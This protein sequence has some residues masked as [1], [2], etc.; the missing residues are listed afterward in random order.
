MTPRAPLAAF[1]TTQLKRYALPALLGAA[2]LVSC[3]RDST[4]PLTAPKLPAAQVIP[5][6]TTL[7]GETL[8]AMEFALTGA[9][10]GGTGSFTFTATGTAAGPFVGTFEETATINVSGGTGTFHADFTITSVNSP[11]PIRGS[12][13]GAVATSCIDGQVTVMGDVSYSANING[14]ADEGMA[15]VGLFTDPSSKL[16]ILNEGFQSFIDQK[17]AI[18]TP[19][20]AVNP[21]GTEHTVTATVYVNGQPKQGEIVVFDVTSPL[22]FTAHGTCETDVNGQC[23]FTYTGPQEADVHTITGCP[24]DQTLVAVS[25]TNVCGLATKIWRQEASTPG[26]VTGGGQILHN[27]KIQG[28][29]FGFNAQLS[30]LGRFH[31]SGVVVDHT[32]KTQIK[33]LDVDRLLIVGTHATFEGNAEVNGVGT[34][35]T[36]DVDDLA[37]PGTRGDTFKIVTVSGYMAAGP[38]TQGN[39]QIHK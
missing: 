29:S 30:E 37:E 38:L 34:R 27:L 22:G 5:G 10:P 25:A 13:D 23:P 17:V 11:T 2:T 8:T 26:K 33:I 6:P 7:T 21:V 24:A 4:G 39:I 9:C 31:G 36:I 3:E 19:S 28:V 18:L 35:Y 16:G 20:I 1:W 14:T 12:K 32:T 15:S